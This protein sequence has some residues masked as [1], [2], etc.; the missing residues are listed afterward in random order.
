MTTAETE[1]VERF[2]DALV[3]LVTEGDDTAWASVATKFV[4]MPVTFAVLDAYVLRLF[5][6][7]VAHQHKDIRDLRARLVALERCLPLDGSQLALD[8]DELTALDGTRR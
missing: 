1:E 2:A 8:L 3:Q 7:I 6:K 5:G 4:K